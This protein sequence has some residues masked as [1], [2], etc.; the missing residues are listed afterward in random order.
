[1]GL[2]NVLTLSE[3]K[4]VLAHEFGHFSQ[5]S[6]KLHRYVY[7][8][9]RI[10][11]DMVIGRDWLDNL[12]DRCKQREDALAAFYERWKDFQYGVTGANGTTSIVNAAN[13]QVKGIESDVSWLALDALTLSASAT[14]VNARTTQNL[15]DLNFQEQVVHSCPASQLAAPTGTQL[16]VTPK[17]KGN[18]TARYQ[19]KVADYESFLQA[20]V[21]HQGS[22]TSQLQQTAPYNLQPNLPKFTTFA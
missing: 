17:L 8:A 13:A 5:N 3:F 6:M 22:S 2:V 21:I 9:N 12:L 11:A 10:I 1:M 14:Y 4:A 7:T 15:C 18:A 20:T 19:F 16:P